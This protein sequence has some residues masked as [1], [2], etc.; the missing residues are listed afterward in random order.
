MTAILT[1]FRRGELLGLQGEDI[2][3]NHN[4]IH[5]RRSLWKGQI[6]SP[7]PKSSVRKVDMAQ[8]FAQELRKHKF[9]CSIK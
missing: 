5:V 7:K 8:T 2:D 4:R 6:V 9:S 1:G 3:W